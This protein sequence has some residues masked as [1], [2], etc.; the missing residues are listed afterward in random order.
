MMTKRFQ[1][2]DYEF[3]PESYSEVSNPLQAIL[4]NV[5]GRRRREMIRDFWEV[6]SV[7]QLENPLLDDCL[8]GEVRRRLEMIHPTFMGGEYLPDH[9]KGEVEIA[10]IELQSTTADVISIR[11]KKRGERITYSICD[12]YDS[13]F[14]VSPK[15]TRNPLTLAQLIGLIDGGMEEGSLGLC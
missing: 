8:S 13:D 15:T 4:M 7:D 10:R 3:R 11:A 12:E 9:R 1:N 5:K 14:N 2:I 6:G